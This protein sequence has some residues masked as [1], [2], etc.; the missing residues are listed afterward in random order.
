[1]KKAIIIILSAVT[2]AMICVLG[3]ACGKGAEIE[4]VTNIEMSYKEQTYDFLSGVSCGSEEVTYETDAVLGKKG[5]YSIVYSAG[6]AQVEATVKIYGEPQ[7]SA[8]DV[9]LSYEDAVA[10]STEKIVAKDSFGNDLEVKMT[11]IEGDPEYLK[12]GAVYTV[13]YTATDKVG[14]SVSFSRKVNVKPQEETDF[15]NLTFDLADESVPFEMD[16]ELVCIVDNRDNIYTDVS[17]ADGE[18]K[19]LN[20]VGKQLGTGKHRLT[21]V[22]TVGY[23]LLTVEVKDEKPLAYRF[24]YG[25]DTEGINNYIYAQGEEIYFPKIVG[26][27]DSEQIFSVT[28]EVLNSAGDVLDIEEFDSSVIGTYTYRALIEHNNETVTEENVFYVVDEKE[29]YNNLFSVNSNQFLSNYRP[30]YAEGSTFEYVGE[31]SDSYGVTYNAVKFQNNSRLSAIEQNLGFSTDI[32][33]EIMTNGSTTITMKVKFAN[34]VTQPA[35]NPAWVMMFAWV[36][37]WNC[38]NN[39][40]FTINSDGWTTLTYDLATCWLRPESGDFYSVDYYGNYT[41]LYPVVGFWL[42]YDY[43]YEPIYIADVKFGNGKTVADEVYY[44][45]A[46]GE[47]VSVG[48]EGVTVKNDE[49]TTLYDDVKITE[50]GLI[51]RPVENSSDDL[52]TWELFGDISGDTLTYKGREYISFSY[53]KGNIVSTDGSALRLDP[54][55]DSLSAYGCDTAYELY[56]STGKPVETFDQRTMSVVL[57]EGGYYLNLKVTKNGMTTEFNNPFYVKGM[58]SILNKVSS[59]ALKYYGY[60]ETVGEEIFELNTG[61]K[62]LWEHRNLSFSSELVSEMLDKGYTDLGI[63]FMPLQGL[64]EDNQCYRIEKDSIIGVTVGFVHVGDSPTPNYMGFNSSHYG[65]WIDLSGLLWINESV[66]DT[67]AVGFTSVYNSR[68]YFKYLFDLQ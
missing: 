56:Y 45:F 7:I 42:P 26:D 68:F 18:F 41:I 33:G 62:N 59:N 34:K 25:H 43:A 5:L 49:E 66:R 60:D 1:M 14:N 12:F 6:G 31:V 19:W 64:A 65:T 57:S 36:S 16:G 44:D 63:M 9:A 47:T 38:S 55:G 21:L 40:E 11:D 67:G 37:D 20:K 30:N 4:G 39:Y 27:G 22:N 2:L 23:G 10:G 15:G 13:S 3:A 35:D 61:S 28:Y 58:D 46:T 52:L 51:K 54:F 53:D 32:L 29:K 17:Y 48:N 8:M 24:D 50:N